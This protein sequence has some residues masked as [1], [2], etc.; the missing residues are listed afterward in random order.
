MRSI[1]GPNGRRRAVASFPDASCRFAKQ[2]QQHLQ[3]QQEQWAR[4]SLNTLA[5]FGL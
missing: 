3:Q 5:E 1:Y 2:R 4:R